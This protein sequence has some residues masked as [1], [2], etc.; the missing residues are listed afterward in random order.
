MPPNPHNIMDKEAL[1]FLI[2]FINKALLYFSAGYIFFFF[3]CS[4]YKKSLSSVN[5]RSLLF[6]YVASVNIENRREEVVITLYMKKRIKFK[7]I[8]HTKI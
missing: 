4:P 7:L 6:E 5:L 8:T 2:S 1:A 3:T